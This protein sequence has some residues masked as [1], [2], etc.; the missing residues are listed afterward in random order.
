MPGC[1]VA[2][3][4]IRHRLPSPGIQSHANAETLEAAR[5]RRPPAAPLVLRRHRPTATL[6][7]K[8]NTHVAA[9]ADRLL[10]THAEPSSKTETLCGEALTQGK[11]VFTLNAPDDARLIALGA[12]PIEPADLTALFA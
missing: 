6:A 5:S 4:G 3:H 2:G 8:R 10:I 12:V 1:T 9:L 7:V 11:P